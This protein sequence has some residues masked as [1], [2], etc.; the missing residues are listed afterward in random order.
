MIKLLTIIVPVW[1]QSEL[2]VRALDSI[3]RRSDIKIIIV[4]DGST[5][6]SFQVVSQWQQAH[7]DV[8]DIL[9]LHN[10]KNLGVGMSKRR[11]YALADS[12]FIYVLDSDDYLLTN[13]F[14]DLL[15]RL[16]FYRDYDIIRIDNELNDGRREHDSHTA[17]WSYLLRNRFKIDYPKVRKAEDWLY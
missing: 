17:G 11:A 5:D 15:D 1:N 14:N 16:D 2:V 8:F 9:V 4:D 10:T 6:N 7:Q 12:E 3:P 13:N